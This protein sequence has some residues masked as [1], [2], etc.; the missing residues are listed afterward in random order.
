MGSG[1]AE[2]L[3]LALYTS[4]RV[5]PDGSSCGGIGRPYRCWKL[6]AICRRLSLAIDDSAFGPFIL[7]LDLRHIARAQATKPK[8]LARVRT[9]FVRR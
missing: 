7:G 5:R 8:Q 9:T 3:R 4:A 2:R 1:S 6:M